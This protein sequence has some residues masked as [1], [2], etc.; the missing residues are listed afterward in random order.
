VPF[1][2]CPT[3]KSEATSSSNVKRFIE[4]KKCHNYR[5]TIILLA[6]KMSRQLLVKYHK[7][8]KINQVSASAY[9]HLQSCI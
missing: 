2:E 9:L 8:L 7:V 3:C 5:L 6:K 4:G 1:Y